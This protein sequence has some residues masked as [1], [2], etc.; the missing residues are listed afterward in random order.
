M[1]KAIWTSL[2]VSLLSMVVP[3]SAEAQPGYPDAYALRPLELPPSLVQVKLPLVVDLS[4]GNAGKLIFMPF[5]LR[6]GVSRELELRLFQ[7]VRGLC[8]RGCDKAYND[9]GVGLLYSVFD[10]NG[11]Q[12]SLLG[13][14]EVASFTSPVQ[15]ALDV[16]LAFK[17]IRAPFSFFA[18]PYLR[19]PL[20]DRAQVDDSINLPIE[21]AFQIATPTALFVETGLYGSAHDGGDW[22]GPIG[23][24]IDQLLQRGVDLGAEFKLNTVLGHTDTGSRLVLVYLVLRG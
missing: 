12:A 21:F 3:T 16:G 23:V 22:S 14:F 19:V 20:S 5:D 8:L 17:V 11:V 6:A 13:A 4:R 9:L 7:P 1:S 18:A 10:E 2:L 15:V 24:G